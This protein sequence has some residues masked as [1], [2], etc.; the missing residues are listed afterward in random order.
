MICVRV[1]GRRWACAGDVNIH[2]CGTRVGGEEGSSSN[3]ALATSKRSLN[4]IHSCFAVI[5]VQTFILTFFSS[6]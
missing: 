4:S 1:G 5:D 2:F 6:F 3:R